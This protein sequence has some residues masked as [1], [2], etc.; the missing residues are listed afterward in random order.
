MY[1]MMFTVSL[2]VVVT[3]STVEAHLHNIYIDP[4]TAEDSFECHTSNSSRIPCKSLEYAF[5]YRMDSTNYILQPNTFYT[6]RKPVDPFKHLK[7]LA[8]SGSESV[9][10]CDGEETGLAFVNV[11][12]LEIVG[13][14]FE[15]CAATRHS[16]SRKVT[17]RSTSRRVTNSV[18]SEVLLYEFKVGLYFYLCANVH[19]KHVNVSL[20]P[21]ATGVVMYDTGGNNTIENSVFM[22]NKVT[23]P[24]SYGGGGFYVEFS[25]CIPGEKYCSNKFNTHPVVGAYYFFMNSTFSNNVASNEASEERP[26]T[27]SSVRIQTYIVPDRSNHQAFGRGGGL[28]VFV[29]GG[30]INNVFH[31]S[32]CRFTN[33]KAQWGGGLFLEFH[34]NA[35]DN[36]AYITDCI[37]SDNECS[38][39][40]ETG[41]GGGG[42]RIGH[43]VYKNISNSKHG[44]YIEIIHSKFLFNSAMY[45]GGLSVS[46]A[47]QYTDIGKEAFLKLENV[48][49]QSNF[50]K[51]GGALHISA[52]PLV[53]KGIMMN[54]VVSSCS[55]KGNS[56]SY[57]DLLDKRDFPHT[58]GIG[59]VYIHQ[60]LNV[61]FKG[62]IYFRDN[63]GTALALTGSAVNFAQSIVNF[64]DNSG[65]RGGAI[66]LLGASYILIDQDTK[67]FFDNNTAT[68]KGGAIYN[69]Y[70]EM[71]D[72]RTQPNCFIRHVDPSFT[73]EEWTATFQFHN[74]L[75][76][77]RQRGNS[78]HSSSL[79]PCSWAGGN[80][81]EGIQSVFCWDD[82]YWIYYDDILQVNCS[83]QITTEPSYIRLRSDNIQVF[84]GQVFMLPI[85]I[86]NDYNIDVTNSTILS[87]TYGGKQA[88]AMEG[89]VSLNRSDKVDLLINAPGDNIL[90]ATFRADRVKFIPCPP[91]FKE[92]GG[93][94]KCCSYNGSVKCD[95]DTLKRLAVEA[96]LAANHWIGSLNDS[97]K[98]F[99]GKCPS[100]FCGKTQSDITLPKKS[101]DLNDVVCNNNRTG[102][103]CGECT[104]GLGPA[105]NSEIYECVECTNSNLYASIAKYLIS[106]YYP[107]IFLFSA[108]ISFDLHLT[109]G[110]A[111]A[112]IL[113]CQMVSS[114]FHLETSAK[115]TTNYKTIYGL[116]NLEFLE[117]LLPPFCL[118]P[119][120]D[121]LTVM[122]LDYG[123]ALSPLI[124]IVIVFGLKKCLFLRENILEHAFPTFILL[125]YTKFSLTLS[126]IV[127]TQPLMDED[128]ATVY[129]SRVYYA[130][131]YESTDPNYF[132]YY[133]LPSAFIFTVFVLA[134]PVFLL[135]LP[136]KIFEQCLC[137]ISF[138]WALYPVERI[139]MLLD[140]F[141][142][143]YK[144]NM[145]FFAGLYFLFRLF[146]IAADCFMSDLVSR[147]L[148]QLKLCMLM[149]ALVIVFQPYNAK[150]NLLN[151]TDA[152]I[153]ANLA[154]VNSWHHYN[155]PLP[156][157]DSI[158]EYA[159]Y[160]PLL[161]MVVHVAWNIYISY[162]KEHSIYQ[163]Q[164][165][166]I[167]G[168]LFNPPVNS[169]RRGKPSTLPSMLLEFIA[170][171]YTEQDRGM[172][173][174]IV[175]IG[176]V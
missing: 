65:Y 67:I 108:L 6:L 3:T 12:N 125:S 173:T 90:V 36:S 38:Y 107:S 60:V 10:S 26:E 85:S 154:L 157:S 113:Y 79:R 37:L 71:D 148:M 132:Y 122:L 82:D 25:Y 73:P 156:F 27:I 69:K 17:R 150:N 63:S 39:T 28:S 92:T 22:D 168:D 146:F 140:A 72:S 81:Y 161:Y 129:P 30:A 89:K 8:L 109:N 176:S 62:E 14:T 66:S 45:G 42:M 155:K 31:I 86:K 143:C 1:G 80:G 163:L 74:N 18:H 95:R 93:V 117:N 55:F 174:G 126:R 139:N 4:A 153:F 44:N 9:I 91:G 5:E 34:D 130:G 20:S 13:V 78:I 103:I 105:V 83:K 11:S 115:I 53:T 21:N 41:T 32:N 118:S 162:F 48:T 111:H 104:S 124:V 70:I 121:I 23:P 170:P 101:A 136:L 43:Y 102:V 58:L 99:V 135:V 96:K 145:R 51:L 137:R 128:D 119:T 87:Y 165:V 29:K 98:Y 49:F 127:K 16:T 142:G 52:F 88:Y 138:L 171:L 159:L 166:G 151:Y 57:A 152:L 141:Q 46:P 77:N 97:D 120:F 94:C 100:S 84:P 112:F 75:D 40:L 133:Q 169:F 116:F 144:E 33:N 164:K 134:P 158:I 172:Q 131:Q 24:N 160:L 19:M 68:D 106:T 47:L 167:T 76:Q 149:I 175:S 114:S 110:P 61:A 56:V 64:T 147:L 2:L 7:F 59:A 50:A 35:T 15:Y 123:L 54:V